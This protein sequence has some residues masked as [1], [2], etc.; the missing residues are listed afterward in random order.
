V[1][2]AGVYLDSSAIIK[3]IFEE[4]ETPALEAFL[5]PVAD[6]PLQPPPWDRPRC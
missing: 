4:P 1:T 5:G 3:L 6:R 2:E